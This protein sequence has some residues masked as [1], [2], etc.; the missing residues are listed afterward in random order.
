MERAFDAYLNHHK[1]KSF[2]DLLFSFIEKSGLKDSEI[3]GKVDID[4]RLFSKIRC[5]KNYI[6]G[7]N[8]VIKLGLALKLKQSEFNELLNSAG[9][10]LR[11]NVDF[12]LIIAYC[13]EK[14]IY[15][16][17]IINDYLYSYT[18]AVL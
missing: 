5:N 9:Y 7:K 14:E 15:D 17:Y 13:L 3:Y 4:R 18:D 1:S 16:L 12:D 6:P 8:T 11:M 10:S 2:Q